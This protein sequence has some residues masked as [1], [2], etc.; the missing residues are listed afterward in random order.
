MKKGGFEV[1]LKR[2]PAGFGAGL[3]KRAPGLSYCARRWKFIFSDSR[4]CRQCMNRHQL[5]FRAEREILH[6]QLHAK[7]RFF[8][9]GSK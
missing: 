2:P 4:L 9:F 3:N 6:F 7:E 8:A 1:V 5:L